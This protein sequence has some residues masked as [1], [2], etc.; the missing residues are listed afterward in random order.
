MSRLV[1]VLVVEEGAGVAVAAVTYGALE[2]PLLR[3]GT[4]VR[5]H[6]AAAGGFATGVGC[7]LVNRVKS[8]LALLT[9]KGSRLED[10][11]AYGPALSEVCTNMC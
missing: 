6:M 8:S 11:P 7:Q 2:R 9:F 4:S 10:P 5:L 3:I 1:G